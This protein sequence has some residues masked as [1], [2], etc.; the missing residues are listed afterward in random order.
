M[1]ATASAPL[2]DK[3]KPIIFTMARLDRVKNLTGL[4]EMYAKSQRL[5]KVANL[6]FVG[7]VIDP[8]KS[9]DRCGSQECVAPAAAV[10]KLPA[11]LGP[12]QMHTG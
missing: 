6:V 4:V 8:E 3:N 7:G 12:G 10:S 9:G 2:Q 5:R 11:Y 1:T